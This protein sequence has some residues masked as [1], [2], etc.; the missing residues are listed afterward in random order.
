M[1]ALIEAGVIGDFRAPYLLRF[2]FAPLYNRYTDVW[3][4]VAAL[5]EIMRTRAWDSPAF[6]WRAVVT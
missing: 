2:G 6:R 4:A 5:S 1:Q 3:D